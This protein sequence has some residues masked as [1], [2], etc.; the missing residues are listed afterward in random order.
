MA[1]AL[2]LVGVL[3]TGVGILDGDIGDE[4]WRLVLIIASRVV[5]LHGKLSRSRRRLLYHRLGLA[6]PLRFSGD[7][8]SDGVV[9]GED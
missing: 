8:G 2:P 6:V 7:G 1:S 9:S 4:S 5:V 3:A